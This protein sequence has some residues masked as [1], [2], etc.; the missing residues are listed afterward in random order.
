ME[1]QMNTESIRKK[2]AEIVGWTIHPKDRFIVIPPK[3]P[4]SVQP[5]STI[6][7]Y[8][9]SA[10]AAL[11]LVEW[12][13]KPENGAYLWFADSVTNRPKYTVSFIS[14]KNATQA[15]ADTFPLALCLAFLKANGINPEAL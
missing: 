1:P 13:A 14:R 2:C 9:E 4:H 15:T 6:P 11:Q 10:D 5:L 3:S 7:N 12:M 8:P